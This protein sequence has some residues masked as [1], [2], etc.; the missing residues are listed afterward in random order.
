MQSIGELSRRTGVKVPTIR[1]YEQMGLLTA[2]ERSDGNQRR[3]SEAEVERL[4]FIK[5]AR[6]LGLPIDSIRELI[7]LGADPERDCAEIDRIAR[8]HLDAIRDKIARLQG[9]ERELDRIVQ[10]CSAGSVGDCYV[11]R[12]L[13]D[14]AF[15]R[16]EHG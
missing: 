13:G 2:P 7:D 9:L 3:Y 10:G 12:S 4:R 8:Q 6:D 15:C 14:H 1:Y 5:H 16:D 11:L